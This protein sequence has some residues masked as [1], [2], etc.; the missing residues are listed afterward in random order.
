MSPRWEP[1]PTS[2]RGRTV[3]YA[4]HAHVV[5]TPKYRRGY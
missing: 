3:V 5:F 2:R 4:L 1:N